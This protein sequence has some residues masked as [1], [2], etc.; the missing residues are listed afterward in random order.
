MARIRSGNAA[1]SVGRPGFKRF[2]PAGGLV[3]KTRAARFSV[4]RLIAR[5][6]ADPKTDPNAILGFTNDPDVPNVNAA[7]SPTELAA[8]KNT[9]PVGQKRVANRASNRSIRRLR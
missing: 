9:T 2:I 1:K 5:D 4:R 3:S 7:P 8:P 6:P